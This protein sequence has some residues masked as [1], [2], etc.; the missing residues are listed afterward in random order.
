[1][2]N[3]EAYQYFFNTKKSLKDRLLDIQNPAHTRNRQMQQSKNKFGPYEIIEPVNK[4]KHMF[5]TISNIVAKGNNLHHSNRNP[6][7]IEEKLEVA[8]F[9]N[10]ESTGTTA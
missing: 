1:M 6:Y 7:H 3:A 4:K 9:N 8:L 2:A 5:S 10:C